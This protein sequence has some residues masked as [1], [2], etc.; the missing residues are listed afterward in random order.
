[1]V[2]ITKECTVVMLATDSESKIRLDTTGTITFEPNI[3][4]LHYSGLSHTYQ[5]LYIT[6]D[7]EIK[8]GDWMWREGEEPTL[9][10]PQFHWDF[11]I[12]YKK[13]IATT[14]SKLTVRHIEET[15]VTDYPL[16]TIPQSFIEEYVKNPVDKVLIVYEGYAL[17]ALKHVEETEH[18][19]RLKLTNNEISIKP[20]EEKMYT[21]AEI[22]KAYDAGFGASKYTVKEHSRRDRANWL[23]ENL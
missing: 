13:I 21:R 8:E 22:I 9:V 14:D 1:M 5:H 6:S 16:P 18:L 23:K 2:T 17:P 7:D 10:V 12:R 15:N 20:L 19:I 11:G 3:K 4:G